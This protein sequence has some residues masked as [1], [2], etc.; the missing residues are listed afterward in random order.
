MKNV[1]YGTSEQLT[2]VEEEEGE[3]ADC[4]LISLLLSF[5]TSSPTYYQ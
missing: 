2:E 3:S 1:G 5:A 4:S